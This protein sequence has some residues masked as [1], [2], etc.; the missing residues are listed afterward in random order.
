MC[1]QFA[2]QT[3]DVVVAQQKQLGQGQLHSGKYTAQRGATFVGSECNLILQSD[4][5]GTWPSFTTLAVDP[6]PPCAM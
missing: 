5:L 2:Q 3:E 4:H 6:S 1:K